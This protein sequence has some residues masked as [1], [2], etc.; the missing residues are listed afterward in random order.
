VERLNPRGAA[1]P[2]VK[3]DRR[4]TVFETEYLIP[5]VTTAKAADGN[6]THDL[7]LTKEVLY[8]LSYSSRRKS[9]AADFI[10]SE[11]DMGGYIDWLERAMGFEPTTSCLEGKSS[12]AELRPQ[13]SQFGMWNSECGNKTT[14]RIPNSELEIG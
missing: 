13:F 11:C 7:F 12:T 3:I 1:I 14:I 5:L 10:G 9:L 2:C 4:S 8:Q 6:R